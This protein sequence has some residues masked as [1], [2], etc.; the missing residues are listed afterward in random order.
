MVRYREIIKEN[1]GKF[2]EDEIFA[3]I[4]RFYEFED[5][6]EIT[7]FDPVT[8]EVNI[9]AAGTME[10][11][12]AQQLLPFTL[13]TVSTRILICK[14]F[15][16]KKLVNM[17][18]FTP[19]SIN[20]A[21]NKLNSFENMPVGID[22]LFLTNNKF[23]SL[24]GLPT[25]ITWLDCAD[26]PLQSLKGLEHCKKLKMLRM[27][28]SVNLPLLRILSMTDNQSVILFYSNFVDDDSAEQ[29]RVEDILMHHLRTY[30]NIKERIYKC[31]YEL[32][33][34]GFKGNAKW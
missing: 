14:N 2:T 12:E 9:Y 3:I 13:H 11:I 6:P 33:K 29:Q 10:L 17:P 23:T 26:N 15:A 24:E 30:S 25:T 5:Q 31:Q 20:C 19:G 28:Y 34:A 18:K 16:L 7:R 32:I 22:E 1:E 21:N 4:Q 8:N 27:T